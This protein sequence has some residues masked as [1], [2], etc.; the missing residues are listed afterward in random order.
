MAKTD[1]SP[2]L[3]RA[4]FLPAGA[5]VAISG[6]LPYRAR[7]A[8]GAAVGRRAVLG[9]PKF[10][11]RVR[12]NLA[13]V[14]PEMAG[15]RRE[16]LVGA[17]GESIGRSFIEMMH[18]RQFHEHRAW[19]PAEG[20]GAEAIMAAAREGGA[21]IVTGH[22][23]QWEAPR[24]WMKDIGINCAAIYRPT[25]NP[26]LNAVYLRNLEFGGT[27]MFPKGRR[28]VRDLMQ[29]VS[30]GGIAAIFPDQYDHRATPLDFLGQPAPTSLVTA[31]I[32]IKLGVPLIPIYGVREPDGEHVQVVAEPPIERGT[33]AEMMQRVNDSLAARVRA[34]PEQYYWLH[35]RWQKDLPG[36]TG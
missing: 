16:A 8:L 2:A 20:P 29:H 31:E 19:K 34:H 11:N 3:D 13:H 36:F 23:G 4:A 21:I 22:F 9:V 15:A 7:L 1:R 6:R 18:N 32:A 28:A 27:P 10:R 24:A 26:H 35:R 12:A 30:R 5:L 17:T 14:F 25:E 33:A